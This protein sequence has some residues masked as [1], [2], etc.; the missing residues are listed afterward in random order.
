MVDFCPL[1]LSGRFSLIPRADVV[2]LRDALTS[3]DGAT[4]ERIVAQVAEQMAPDGY[5][6]LG[7][8]E[9]LAGLDGSFDAAEVADE[10]CYRPAGGGRT[11]SLRGPRNLR[12]TAFAR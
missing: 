7:A 6:F 11:V 2:L 12:S 5:L 1:D 9:V 3:F 8:G 4:A 10:P